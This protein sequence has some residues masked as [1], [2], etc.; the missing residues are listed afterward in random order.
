MLKEDRNDIMRVGFETMKSSKKV[1]SSLFFLAILFLAIL[2]LLFGSFFDLPIAKGMFEK[3]GEASKFLSLVI[4]LPGYVLFALSGAMV[5]SSFSLANKTKIQ[6]ILIEIP[7]FLMPIASG[8]LYGYFSLSNLLPL[9]F[10]FLTGLFVMGIF[11]ALWLWMENKNGKR[12]LT[13]E[14][15]AIISSFLVVLLVIWILNEEL[16]RY[17]YKAI[18]IKD[19]KEALFSAWW[20]FEGKDPEV[21]KDNTISLSLLKGGPSLDVALSA[22]TLFVP[23]VLPKGAKEKTWISGLIIAFFVL[24][25]IFVELSVGQYFLSAI[26]WGL[27]IG[28]TISGLILF[29]VEYPSFKATKQ[30]PKRNEKTSLFKGTKEAASKALRIQKENSIRLQR[31]RKRSRNR[32]KQIIILKS[33][34]DDDSDP[35]K[36]RKAQ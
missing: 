5:V 23:F 2:L 26:A 20:A 33:L 17:S 9:P 30:K 34:S 25:G 12:E 24:L 16:L 32:K 11:E 18:V 6:K 36:E 28:A 7:I 27:G 3:M 35:S 22:F 4:P 1:Y 14:A 13:K 21:L 31:N 8:L 10:A 19:G 15:F 29:F